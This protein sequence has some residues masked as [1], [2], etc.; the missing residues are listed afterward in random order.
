MK[1]YIG[2]KWVDKS[3][4]ISVLNP[5]D[6]S[7]IDTIPKANVEDVETAVTTAERGAKAMA[8]LPAFERYSFLRKTADLLAARA[9]DFARTITLEAGKP[10]VLRNPDATRPW[11]HVL[12]PLNGYLTLAAALVKN[13]EIFRGAWNFGPDVG[14]G[15]TVGDLGERAV[16]YWGGGTVEHSDLQKLLPWLDWAWANTCAEHAVS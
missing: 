2:G 3:E 15:L 12:D 4:K 9:D 11:Q 6:G 16:K 14:A 8:A 10:I 1:M 5:Y 13:P 7:G